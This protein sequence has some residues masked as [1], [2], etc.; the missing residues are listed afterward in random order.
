LVLFAYKYLQKL[1]PFL[2]SSIHSNRSLMIKRQ[3]NLPV[4][5]FLK[6]SKEVRLS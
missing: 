6:L 4:N 2:H 5:A 1:K 3:I